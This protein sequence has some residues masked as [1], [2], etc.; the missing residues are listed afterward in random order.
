MNPA[1]NKVY[2][3]I[4]HKFCLVL[5]KILHSLKEMKNNLDGVKTC[6]FLMSIIKSPWGH[7]LL[8]KLFRGEAS[9]GEG[10]V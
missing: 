6:Y 7:H 2:I 1:W 4:K 9:D 5:A 8:P 10:N 3:K